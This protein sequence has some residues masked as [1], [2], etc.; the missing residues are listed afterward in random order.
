M[1][2]TGRRRGCLTVTEATCPLV[3]PASGT[4]GSWPARGRQ[5]AGVLGAV[6][7]WGWGLTIM[8]SRACLASQQLRKTGMKRLRSGAQNICGG[9][10]VRGWGLGPRPRPRLTHR[11]D[12]GQRVDHFQDEGH[13]QDL[14][15]DV[16]LRSQRGFR[17]GGAGSENGGAGVGGAGGGP[18][19]GGPHLVAEV[20]EKNG[21]QEADDGHDDLRRDGL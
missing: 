20:N 13:A 4:Q 3:T 9:S 10:R 2:W 17:A 11:D 16:A 8:F 7:R 6:R 19:L 1:G 21:L 14:L 15:P 12:E 5:A 18:G